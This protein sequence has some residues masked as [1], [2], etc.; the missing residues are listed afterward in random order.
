LAAYSTIAT[1][2]IFLRFDAEKELDGLDFHFLFQLKFILFIPLKIKSIRYCFLLLFAL[3]IVSCDDSYKSSI[4]DYPVYLE[5]DLA[6]TYPNF[7]SP[8]QFLLFD[9]PKIVTDRIG[10]GGIFVYTGFDESYYA[11]DMACPYEAKRNILVY[12]DST[13]LPQVKCR[14]CGSV[15]DVGYGIGNP[16][17]GPSQEVLKRYRASKQGSIL[18]ITR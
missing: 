12:P 16:S 15:Y 5:L 10:F 11:F 6:S 7:N 1:G 13:G 3:L 9:K 4:P 8:N 2:P 17:T 14:T 18:Y